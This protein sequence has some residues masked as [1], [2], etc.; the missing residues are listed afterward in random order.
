MARSAMTTVLARPLGGYGLSPLIFEPNMLIGSSSNSIETK[1]KKSPVYEMIMP[2]FD[3]DSTNGYL[4]MPPL[5]TKTNAYKKMDYESIVS[6]GNKPLGQE[7]SFLNSQGLLNMFGT[8]NVYADPVPRYRESSKDRQYMNPASGNSYSQGPVQ[9]AIQSVR[10]VEVK[11]VQN[12]YQNNEPQVIDI[13]PSALPIVINFRTTSSQ[14]QIHQTHE[15]AEP[16]EVQQTQSEDEPQY[17]K[18]QVTKPVIQEVHEIIMP[19]RKITQEIRPV[20]EEVKTIV[21]RG[22]PRDKGTR[23]GNSYNLSAYESNKPKALPASAKYK[24]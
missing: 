1:V 5:P 9:A 10:S 13:P 24:S 18:H 2:N 6:K 15:T 21:A 3:D 20:E 4:N 17:L 14:I 7:P 16:A 22:K 11:D 23:N 19:Y 8:N 12:E